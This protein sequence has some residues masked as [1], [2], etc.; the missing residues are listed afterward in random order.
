MNRADRE[1]LYVLLVGGAGRRHAGAPVAVARRECAR[2]GRGA[3]L[4][5]LSSH[6]LPRLLA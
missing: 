6:H 3:A 4:L 5:I 1:G 2:R